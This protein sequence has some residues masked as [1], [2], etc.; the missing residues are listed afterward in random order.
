M[1]EETKKLI[2]RLQSENNFLKELIK[3]NYKRALQ[4]LNFINNN[5]FVHSEPEILS[6]PTAEKREK[7][8]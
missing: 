3:N 1:T 4:T 7:L 2:N 8:E 5:N 6:E